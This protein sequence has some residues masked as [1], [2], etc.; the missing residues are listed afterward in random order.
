MLRRAEACGGFGAIL[1]RG[2]AERGALLLVVASR[3]RYAAILERVLTLESAYRWN[4]VGPDAGSESPLVAEFLEKR[5]RFDADCWVI[6]LDIPNAER[7]IAE[8]TDMG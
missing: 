6:E 2:D 5:A 4:R 1:K 8:T 3:G 7:F